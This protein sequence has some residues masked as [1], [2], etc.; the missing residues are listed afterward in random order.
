MTVPYCYL[1]SSCFGQRLAQQKRLV[2]FWRSLS[3]LT[4]VIGLVLVSNA[5][6]PILSYELTNTR[7]TQR[8]IS[9]LASPG[10]ILGEGTGVNYTNPKSWFPKAPVFPPRPSQIT[11]YNLSIPEL[12]I[13]QA[14]VQI[15]GEDLMKNLVQYPGTALPGQYGNMVIFG[16]SVL[17]Q[18]FNPRNYKT[19]FST[20]PRLEEGDEILIDFDGISYCYQ[21]RKVIETAAEDISVLEQTYDSQWLSLITCVPP[22]TYLKRLV[23]RAQLI[24]R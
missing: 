13:E 2:L 9:P 10:V 5:L 16:H 7:F 23:V 3:L 14:T 11:H 19:I 17:P 22:G 20:L 15:G 21:V 1:K 18:F 12:G 6:W 4:I 8:L 24:E